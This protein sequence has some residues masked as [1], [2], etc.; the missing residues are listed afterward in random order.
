MSYDAAAG[1]LAVPYI[2]TMLS[3]FTSSTPPGLDSRSR[4]IGGNARQ[5]LNVAGLSYFP[6]AGTT[7]IMYDVISAADYS[8]KQIATKAVTTTDPWTVLNYYASNTYD[9]LSMY[10]DLLNAQ[11]PVPDKIQFY[12]NVIK[13]LFAAASKAFTLP[14]PG[15]LTWTMYTQ[16][17]GCYGAQYPDGTIVT[18]T[19]P[20][21]NATIYKTNRTYFFEFWPTGVSKV[22]SDATFYIGMQTMIRTQCEN[23]L[24]VYQKLTATG[25]PWSSN[26][27]KRD[28]YGNDPN[29]DTFHAVRYDAR[30]VGQSL[31]S[32]PGVFTWYYKPLPQ[33]VLTW[34]GEMFPG[35][36]HLDDA[37]TYG[38][39]LGFNELTATQYGLGYLLIIGDTLQ[40]PAD[41]FWGLT[42]VEYASVRAIV[43]MY[44]LQTGVGDSAAFFH[45]YNNVFAHA[46]LFPTTTETPVVYKRPTFD[47]VTGFSGLFG[48]IDDMMGNA[49]DWLVI[50]QVSPQLT[51]ES[52]IGKWCQGAADAL[53]QWLTDI[54][55]SSVLSAVT[56]A[57]CS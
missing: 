22:P 27:L 42:D 1:K 35:L 7:S 45:A 9:M 2:N 43:V 51:P 36:K 30:A 31:P 29:I 16:Y 48:E 8:T 19:I 15:K 33:T 56:G 26:I 5:G 23:V 57:F 28:S 50:Y 54:D 6:L 52:D 3:L 47:K 12:G 17:P 38:D 14:L 21:N 4:I 49:H 41:A 34:L 25:S 10:S 46:Q 32:A 53:Y 40:Y 13:T 44:T 39:A 24:Y 20:C 18:W 37:H 55:F 11:P